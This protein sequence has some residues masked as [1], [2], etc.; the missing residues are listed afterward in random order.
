MS[1]PF[2]DIVVGRYSCVRQQGFM[3]E[4]IAT[5]GGAGSGARPRERQI[6]DYQ[7]QSYRWGPS[8]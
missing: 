2:L 8:A 5:V 6:I 1:H 3:E 7:V 4:A